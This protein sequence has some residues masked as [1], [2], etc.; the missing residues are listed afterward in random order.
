VTFEYN[1]AKDSSEVNP[2]EE[3]ELT[4][5]EKMENLNEFFEQLFTSIDYSLLLIFLGTFIV[6]ENMASTGIPKYFW[7]ELKVP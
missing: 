3:E 5:A 6:V 1:P 4:S 2:A 7:W